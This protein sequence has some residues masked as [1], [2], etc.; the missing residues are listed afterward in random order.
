MTVVSRGAS[1]ALGILVAAFL[2]SSLDPDARQEILR[3]SDPKPALTEFR[4]WLGALL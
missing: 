3:W 1:V 4:T 2:G